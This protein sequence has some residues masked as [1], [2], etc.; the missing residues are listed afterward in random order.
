[1]T[2]IQKYNLICHLVT[3][4]TQYYARMSANNTNAGL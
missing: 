4:R 1:M 2:D 3:S